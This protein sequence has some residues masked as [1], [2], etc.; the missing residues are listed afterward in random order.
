[1]EPED[2]VNFQLANQGEQNPNP[3]QPSNINTQIDEGLATLITLVNQLRGARE[4]RRE[5]LATSLDV[6][7]RSIASY[8]GKLTFIS[9]YRARM[10]EYYNIGLYR[11]QVEDLGIL[12]QKMISSFIDPRSEQQPPMTNKIHLH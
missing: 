10:F 11:K 8:Q 4:P 5:S 2:N 3:P 12:K 6:I 9:E 7:V 1:M